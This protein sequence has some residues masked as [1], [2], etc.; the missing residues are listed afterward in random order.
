[1]VVH[2]D[3]LAAHV[4]Y[5]DVHLER[6]SFLQSL[7]DGFAAR[8][9]GDR[10]P[11]V[12]GLAQGEPFHLAI[13]GSRP[14]DEPS[15]SPIWP[16]LGSRLVFLIDW[17]RARKAL[18]SFLRGQ[19]RIALLRWAAAQE[20][21]HRAFLVLGGDRPINQAIEAASGGWRCISATACATSWATPLL[22][23]LV[24]FVLRTASEGLRA[25]H[26]QGLIRDRVRAELQTHFSNEG[27]RS[28]ARGRGTCRPGRSN[29]APP[30][31]RRHRRGGHRRRRAG[32]AGRGGR[33]ASSTTPT[34]W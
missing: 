11:A 17:N 2:V 8:L 7:F 12:A 4:T 28:V 24:R 13:G 34:W 15:R 6:L 19:A 33:P 9:G 29:I 20:L 26:S 5:T 1:M 22:V 25:H 27:K 16:F 32:Q 10:Q 3:G 21:G 23:E 30:G 18:R 31:A 14:A